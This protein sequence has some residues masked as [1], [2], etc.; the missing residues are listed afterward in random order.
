MT[1]PTILVADATGQTGSAV[2]AQLREKGVPVK[3][4]VRVR[5]ARSARLERLG[6]RIA[7][8]DLFDAEQLVAAMKGTHRAYYCPPFHTHMIHSAVAF[9]VA[10]REAK[11]ESVVGLTQ[12]LASASHPSLSTR[13][14]WLVDRLLA[15]L[16]DIG[17]TIVN[18]GLFAEYPYLALMG[19]ASQL[20]LFPMPGDGMS[21]NAPPSNED[22]ARVAVAA[23]MDPNTHAGK[24]YRPTGPTLI[25][26]KDMASILSRVLGRTVR[27]VPIP[28]WMFF[29]AARMDGTS[30]ILLHGL[31]YYVQEQIRG[32]FEFGAPTNHV[33]EVTGRQPEDFETIARR[34][35]T[36]PGVQR[37]L[38]NQ[39][40]TFLAFMSVPM[41]PGF[42]PDRFATE[43]TFP[44]LARPL[45]D[46]DNPRWKLE[47][48]AQS[49]TAAN[50]RPLRAGAGA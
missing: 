29:K 15:D 19:Y 35:A 32:T 20:G 13:Q 24:T 39:L 49:S 28:M 7:V 27:H 37:T 22:I 50:V 9:T 2:V 38:G 21:R 11:L 3:A 33:L 18:P 48:S 43:Q 8:A 23:L 14:H 45:L 47:H 42:R 41:R 1:H 4:V 25:S 46:L 17:H 31:K 10:A 40:K 12:W 5:D 6:A 34:H 36:R 30:P 16:P 44:T 26:V